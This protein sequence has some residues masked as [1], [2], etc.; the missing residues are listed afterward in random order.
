MIHLRCKIIKLRQITDQRPGVLG[1]DVPVFVFPVMRG[2]APKVIQPEG[3][4]VVHILIYQAA[5]FPFGLFFIEF[6]GIYG[7][8]P[9]RGRRHRQFPQG[10][11]QLPLPVEP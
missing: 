5:H 2:A 8:Q 9:V 7:Q 11:P 4:P 3:H 6:V 10:P 1:M